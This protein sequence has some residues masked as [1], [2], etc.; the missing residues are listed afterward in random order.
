MPLLGI[1]SKST[2]AEK[3]EGVILRAIVRAGVTITRR[4]SSVT[5]PVI[6]EEGLRLNLPILRLLVKSYRKV[7]IK[8]DV[9]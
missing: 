7:V 5:S 9:N 2:R 1:P 3:T 6:L 4:L 8:E